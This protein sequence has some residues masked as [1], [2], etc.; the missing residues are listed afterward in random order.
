MERG[1]K[2]LERGRA[3]EGM[4]FRDRIEM[5]ARILTVE[6]ILAEACRM[7]DD[8]QNGAKLRRSWR[9][10]DPS[11]SAEAIHTISNPNRPMGPSVNYC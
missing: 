6:A 7:Q 3:R 4:G 2:A 9:E 5:G 10:K 11:T 1:I 8:Y